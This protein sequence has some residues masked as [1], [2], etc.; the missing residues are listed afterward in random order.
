[1]KH[2]LRFL[3]ILAAVMTLM[4]MTASIALA[5]PDETSK[6][7][8]NARE[9]DHAGVNPPA[10][11]NSGKGNGG[12]WGNPATADSENNCVDCGIGADAMWM[13]IIH[14]PTCAAYDAGP[15][16]H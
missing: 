7:I 1:M 10:F 6:G 2:G 5:H 16:D 9:V 13:Q 15:H 14:N 3:V 4:I 12:L 8:A 11:S